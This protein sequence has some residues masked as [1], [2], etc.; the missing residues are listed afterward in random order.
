MH[1]VL[2]LLCH[3]AYTIIRQLILEKDLK[4][5]AANFLEKFITSPVYQYFPGELTDISDMKY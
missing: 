2:S 1:H 5:H 3:I 4:T